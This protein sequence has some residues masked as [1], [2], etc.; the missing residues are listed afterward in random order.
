LLFYGNSKKKKGEDV[1]MEER[2]ER[3]EDA[4]FRSNES[5]DSPTVSIGAGVEKK[6]AFKR[7]LLP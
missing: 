2:I 3:P 7:D 6:G 1:T 4:S 5:S